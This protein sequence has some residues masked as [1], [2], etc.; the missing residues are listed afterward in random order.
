MIMLVKHGYECNVKPK[1]KVNYKDGRYPNKKDG[2]G[3]YKR[4]KE[5]ERK[6]VK[7]KECIM[8]TKGANL[9]DFSVSSNLELMHLA[10]PLKDHY[11]LLLVLMVHLAH[12]VLQAPVVLLLVL[13]RRK[14]F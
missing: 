12:K 2:L 13:Q 9:K 10:A 4:V 8:F 14:K 11:K 5:N 6:V 3:H 1:P 7:G